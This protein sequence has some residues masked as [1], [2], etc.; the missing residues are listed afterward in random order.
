[1]FFTQALYQ[2]SYRCHGF[3]IR[4]G[5]PQPAPEIFRV[6]LHYLPCC[7]QAVVNNSIT[8]SKP[9]QVLPHFRITKSTGADTTD[10][11]LDLAAYKATALPIKLYQQKTGADN[12]I[13]TRTNRMVACH[14]IVTPYPQQAGHYPQAMSYPVKQVCDPPK[15]LK[16]RS[17]PNM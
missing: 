17:T 13:Q 15:V 14:A 9:N 8:G 12:V 11:N 6:V 4:A 1:M 16:D 7:C 10:L 3:V 2:L 5:F